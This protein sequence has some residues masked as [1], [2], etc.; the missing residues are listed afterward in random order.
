[1]IDVINH[2]VSFEAA[3]EFSCIRRM[4]RHA[5]VECTHASLEH[6][7][8]VWVG[9]AAEVDLLWEDFRDEVLAA[10]DESG[11]EV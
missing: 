11:N 7:A 8:H 2:V 9:C 10:D 6:L 3:S 4:N 5:R 1:M